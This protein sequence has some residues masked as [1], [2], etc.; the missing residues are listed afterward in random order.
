M[1]CGSGTYEPSL[2]KGGAV[3]EIMTLLLSSA[4][5]QALVATARR[6]TLRYGGPLLR[7]VAHFTKTFKILR[8]DVHYFYNVFYSSAYI[9]IYVDD[10]K[11]CTKL[12]YLYN[13]RSLCLSEQVVRKRREA[14][15]QNILPDDKSEQRQT[16]TQTPRAQHCAAT[17]GLVNCFPPL[18]QTSSTFYIAVKPTRVY[19]GARPQ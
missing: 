11:I 13:N 15:V 6:D 2:C 12:S 14:A 9:Y 8:N 7:R 18:D 4:S 16:H 17:P 5:I 1:E 3:A 19:L 10:T